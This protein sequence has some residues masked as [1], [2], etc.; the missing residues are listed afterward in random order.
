[1]EDGKRIGTRAVVL[2]LVIAAH[3]VTPVAALL[4]MTAV[5]GRSHAGPLSPLDR[6]HAGLAARLRTDVAAIAGAPHNLRHPRQLEQAARHIEHA[7]ADIGYTVRRQPFAAGGRQ[8]RNI[9]VVVDPAAADAPTLV[10]G[11]HYDSYGDVPGANDNGS[12]TAAVLA[13]ARG[14]ADLRGR[15]ALRI[16][17]VLFVNEEPPWFQ[18]EGMGSLVYARRLARNRERAWACFR[19]RRSAIIAT[20]PA[21][22]IIRRRSTCS[23][24]GPAI[25]W[26]SSG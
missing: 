14:L 22:S 12:G 15:S 1:M 6:A 7:L 19:S 4:W 21:A 2:I 26:P 20:A 10:I 13:L 18:T 9:E 23:A 8:V 5:P 25:S 3:I 16:R 11:A 24:P 17:L